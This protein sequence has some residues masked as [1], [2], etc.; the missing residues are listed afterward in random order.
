MKKHLQKKLSLSKTVQILKILKDKKII[1]RMGRRKLF[2]DDPKIFLYRCIF[3]SSTLFSDGVELINLSGTG[4]SYIN[5]NEAI[6]KCINEAVERYSLCIHPTPYIKIFKSSNNDVSFIEKLSKNLNSKIGFIEGNDLIT[7][8]K[9]Y[10]PAQMVFLNYQIKQGEAKFMNQ[11][12]SG[13]AA[14]FS[15]EETLLGAIYEII[16]RDTFLTCY[17]NKYP[18]YK[19]DTTTIKD[20]LTQNYINHTKAYGIDVNI[21]YLIN[22]LNIPTILCILTDKSGFGPAVSIGLKCTPDIN[23]GI[24]GALSEAMMIRYWMKVN[25]FLKMKN[26]SPLKK[27]KIENVIDRAGYWTLPAS[28]KKLNFLLNQK[29]VSLPKSENNLNVKEQ[30]NKVIDHFK[31]I[32]KQLYYVNLTQPEFGETGHRVY[33]VITPSLQPLYMSEEKR[34]KKIKRIKEVANFLKVFEQINKI[35]HPLL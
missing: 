28:I 29:T 2:T 11:T 4:C 21:I 16:E 9:T 25:L 34:F 20:S 19:I 10:I 24:R 23:S 13:T 18:G 14:G 17:L 22:D 35:P 6:I 7:S 3:Q 33:K 12:S 30:L 5:K 1:E 26:G 8:N 31:K 27:T 32:Q 15:H